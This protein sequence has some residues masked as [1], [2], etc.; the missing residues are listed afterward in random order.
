MKTKRALAVALIV[1]A[2]CTVCSFV[3]ADYGVVDKGI[4]PE[5]WPKELEPLR[6]QSKTYEGPMQANRHYMIPFTKREAFE[7]AW[8]HILKVKSEL[9]PIVLV[10]ATKKA[11]FDVGPAGVAIH[12][13]PIERVIDRPFDPKAGVQLWDVTYIVLTVDGDVVDLN[14]I[15]FPA[16]TPIIDQRFVEEKKE[17]GK[18]VPAP[19]P[20][21]EPDVKK[22]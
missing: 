6:K 1:F 8:P 18:K 10:K 12:T 21:A 9:A 15:P 11:F 2:F 16:D 17:E 14:R 13:P 5:G 3:N 22:K 4:W 7:A 20:G 19:A